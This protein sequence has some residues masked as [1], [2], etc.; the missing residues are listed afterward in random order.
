[1]E[2]SRES[3]TLFCTL[4]CASRWECIF[5]PHNGAFFVNYVTT[6]AFVGTG[7]ELCRFPELF[8]YSMRLLSARSDAE[9]HTVKKNQPYSYDYG[10]HYAWFLCIFAITMAYTI[11]CPLVTPIGKSI[12][13]P[14]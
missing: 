13:N 8:M 9:R 11:S 6:A 1:M 2:R 4:L 14:T 10:N 7:M 5:L 12:S 3:Y